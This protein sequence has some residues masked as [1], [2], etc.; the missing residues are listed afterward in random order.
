MSNDDTLFIED[1]KTFQ[2]EHNFCESRKGFCMMPKSNSG[3]NGISYQGPNVWNTLHYDLK[4]A[5]NVNSF[6]HKIR[7]KFFK[8]PAIS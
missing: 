8:R 6:K 4:S 3:Q 5:N 7:D 1:I 2:F